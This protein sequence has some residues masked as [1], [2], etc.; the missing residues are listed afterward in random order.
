MGLGPGKAKGAPLR[1]SVTPL[2]GEGL[3]VSGEPEQVS[4]RAREHAP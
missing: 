1:Q 4:H 3:R 2:E